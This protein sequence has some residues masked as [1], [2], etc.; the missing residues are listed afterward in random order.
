MTCKLSEVMCYTDRQL[1][2]VILSRCYSALKP[3]A[4][5]VHFSTNQIIRV[6]FV[7]FRDS[8][9]L[10]DGLILVVLMRAIETR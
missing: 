3:L 9:T 7:I 10:N 2:H 8:V 6:W 5:I 1:I 4:L